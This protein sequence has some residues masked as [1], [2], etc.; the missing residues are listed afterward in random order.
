MSTSSLPVSSRSV[1]FFASMVRTVP[2]STE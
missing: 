2:V 1:L